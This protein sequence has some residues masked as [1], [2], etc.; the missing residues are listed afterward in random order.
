MTTQIN[1]TG[2]ANPT[3]NDKVIFRVEERLLRSETSAVMVEI[4]CVGGLRD[5]LVGTVRVFLSTFLKDYGS[6]DSSGMSFSAQQVRRP[7]GRAPQGILNLGIMI[8]DGVDLHRMNRF[9]P[10]TDGAVDF[11]DLTRNHVQPMPSFVKKLVSIKTNNVFYAREQQARCQGFNNLAGK[12]EGRDQEKQKDVDEMVEKKEKKKLV[13]CYPILMAPKLKRNKV[14]LR[15]GVAKFHRSPSDSNLS[16]N[17][18]QDPAQ[19]KRDP[20]YNLYYHQ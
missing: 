7:S 10:A 11:R 4:Y 20:N 19:V 16:A 3:W 14:G 9:N 13:G 5:K 17:E 18:N 15:N 6:P 2:G 1:R 12:E 8:L